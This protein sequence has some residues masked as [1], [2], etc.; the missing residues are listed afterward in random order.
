MTTKTETAESVRLRFSSGEI[1]AEE[2]LL[3]VEPL[4]SEFAVDPSDEAPVRR[5]VNAIERTVFTEEDP[6]RLREL[7][8]LLDEAVSFA[9]A[10]E[11]G[12]GTAL[13]DTAR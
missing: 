9:R 11:E 12:A 5:L 2:L 8:R 4:L 1:A 7:A 10:R 3:H 13:S 6:Q